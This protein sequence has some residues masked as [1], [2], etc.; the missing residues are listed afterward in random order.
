MVVDQTD[1]FVTF[2]FFGSILVLTTSTSFLQ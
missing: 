2:S 1:Q